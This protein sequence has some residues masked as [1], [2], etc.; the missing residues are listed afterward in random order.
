MPA[1]A[2]TVSLTVTMPAVLPKMRVPLVACV[3]V[4][5]VP[6][7][8]AQLVPAEVHVPVPPPPAPGAQ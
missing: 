6:A 7:E 3:S 8:D 1:A 5:W 2:D 4:P